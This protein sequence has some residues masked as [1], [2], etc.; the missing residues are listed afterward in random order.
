MCHCLEANGI[1]LSVVYNTSVKAPMTHVPSDM[2]IV[3]SSYHKSV[4]KRTVLL[5]NKF[6]IPLLA[7]IY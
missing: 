4:N 3:I 7:H 1:S 2:T 6:Y 5:I